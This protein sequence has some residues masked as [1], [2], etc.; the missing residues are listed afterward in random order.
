MMM[1]ILAVRISS[2]PG[3]S[4]KALHKFPHVDTKTLDGQIE[5]RIRVSEFHHSGKIRQIPYSF[6]Y[7]IHQL[8]TH[9][10]PIAV[11]RFSVRVYVP[12]IRAVI[13][14]QVSKCWCKFAAWMDINLW[15]N[16]CKS[17]N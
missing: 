17:P 2:V 13:T 10:T 16:S 4:D 3:I 15:Q 6:T 1:M 11:M 5:K 7:T 14:R 8:T 9:L 12:L